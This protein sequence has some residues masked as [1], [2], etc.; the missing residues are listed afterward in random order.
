MSGG[1]AVFARFPALTWPDVRDVPAPDMIWDAPE[2]GAKVNDRRQKRRATRTHPKNR[3]APSPQDDQCLL[4]QDP[5]LDLGPGRAQ[6][7]GAPFP[8][9]GGIGH[10]DH[11]PADARVDEGLPIR[12]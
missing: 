10:R 6:H 4:A 2:P 12:P 9:G 11:D 7:C 3:A 8:A 5:G 1:R